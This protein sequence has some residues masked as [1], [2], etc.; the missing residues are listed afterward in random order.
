MADARISEAGFD[1]DQTDRLLELVQ[2]SEGELAIAA[3]RA[4]GAL[5]LPTAN[6]VKLLTE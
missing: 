3:A 4:H 2:S 5:S 1:L 6:A